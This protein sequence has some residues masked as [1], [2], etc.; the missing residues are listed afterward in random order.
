MSP[1]YNASAG[2]CEKRLIVYYGGLYDENR[3]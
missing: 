1:L 2:G 3:D